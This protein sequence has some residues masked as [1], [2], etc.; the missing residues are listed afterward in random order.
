MSKEFHSDGHK[1]ATVISVAAGDVYSQEHHQEDEY[2]DANHA[3]FGQAAR[4]DGRAT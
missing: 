3:A 4:C 2:D 1:H